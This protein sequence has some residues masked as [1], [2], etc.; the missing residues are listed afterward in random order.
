MAR[1]TLEDRIQHDIEKIDE[2]IRAAARTVEELQQERHRLTV[3]LE[4]LRG[5]TR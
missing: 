2:K 4:A 5:E 3:A 1:T